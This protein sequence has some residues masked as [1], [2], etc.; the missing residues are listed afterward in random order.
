MTLVWQATSAGLSPQ[1]KQANPNP[2]PNLNP[3]PGP[4]PN[5]GYLASRDEDSADAYEEA[6]RL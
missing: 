6:R 3:D 5:P 4:N 2:N 1:L